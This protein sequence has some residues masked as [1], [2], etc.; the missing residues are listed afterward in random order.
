MVGK[1]KYGYLEKIGIKNKY[2]QVNSLIFR[3]GEMKFNV[4]ICLGGYMTVKWCKYLENAI[5]IKPLYNKVC[6]IF[7][8]AILCMKFRIILI[9]K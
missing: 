6:S 7:K 5:F 3:F 2:L 8:P 4:G 9:C 1:F